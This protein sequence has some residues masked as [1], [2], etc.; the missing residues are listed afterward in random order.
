[1][2][3][4]ARRFRS[5]SQPKRL[6]FGLELF[7]EALGDPCRGA[8]YHGPLAGN[9]PGLPL[10]A[11]EVLADPP[12]RSPFQIEGSEAAQ[13][14]VLILKDRVAELLNDGRG[15]GARISSADPQAHG[16]APRELSTC[17]SHAGIVGGPRCRG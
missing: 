6:S 12:S 14:H 1:M 11:G 8:K 13:L 9:L 3:H 17:D 10:V 15:D 16:N 2:R 7:L 4:L 5:L